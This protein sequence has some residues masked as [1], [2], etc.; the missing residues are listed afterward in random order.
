MR[1]EFYRS[2]DPKNVLG[3]ATWSA[4][5][6]EVTG[7]GDLRD[8]LRS[9]FRATPVAVDDPAIRSAGTSGPVVLQPGTL[10]WFRAA[11]QERGKADGF[12]VRFVPEGRDVMG[13]DPAG[14][15]RT[16]SESVERKERAGQ[17]DPKG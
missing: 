12:D 1:A 16:F 13:W 14:A 10:L 8:R 11:A 4:N 6:V 9:I 3:A 7:D 2:D 5:G 17:R 15:Y